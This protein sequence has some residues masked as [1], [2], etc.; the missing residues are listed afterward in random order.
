MTALI[1]WN[2]IMSRWHFQSH[3]RHQLRVRGNMPVHIQFNKPHDGNCN[4]TL[5]RSCTMYTDPRGRRI[6][7]DEHRRTCPS[8][9]PEPS[10]PSPQA[11]RVLH[12][13]LGERPPRRHVP[14]DA[15][16]LERSYEA[17]A[18]HRTCSHPFQVLVSVTCRCRC[19]EPPPPPVHVWGFRSEVSEKAEIRN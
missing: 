2:I 5:E 16:F 14:R 18:Q 15:F 1:K 19:T 12:G 3:H 13:D 6:L 4:V 9:R 7:T 11:A 8:A 17:G 10:P